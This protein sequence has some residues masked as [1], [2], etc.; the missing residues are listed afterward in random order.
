MHFASLGT[1]I[2]SWKKLQKRFKYKIQI[3][4]LLPKITNPIG[5]GIFISANPNTGS[6]RI[7]KTLR[8]FNGSDLSMLLKH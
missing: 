2:G 1:A 3:S 7:K 5:S 6:E 8:K 4:L